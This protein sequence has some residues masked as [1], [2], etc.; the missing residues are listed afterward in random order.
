MPPICRGAKVVECGSVWAVMKGTL[1]YLLWALLAPAALFFAVPMVGDLTGLPMDLPAALEQLDLRTVDWRFRLR[2]PVRP[3]EKIVIVAL[4]QKSVSALGEPPWGRGVNASLLR[5]AKEWGARL[6]VFDMLFATPAARDRKGDDEFAAAVREAGNVVLGFQTTSSPLVEQPMPAVLRRFCVSLATA[7]PVVPRTR[8]VEA[9]F[10]DLLDACRGLGFLNV[11]QDA[12]GAFRNAFALLDYVPAGSQPGASMRLPSLGLAA[13]LALEGIAPA[14]VAFKEGQGLS[15]GGTVMPTGPGSRFAVNF[16]GPAGTFPTYS[17]SDVVHGEVA[18]ETFKGAVVLVGVVLPGAADVRPNPFNLTAYGVELQA[19]ILH[20]ILTRSWI[21][22]PPAY[23]FYVLVVVFSL[24]VGVVVPRIRLWQGLVLV[25][26]VSSIYVTTAVKSFV[27]TRLCLEVVPPLGW[28]GIAYVAAALQMLRAERKTRE[29]VR[30]SFERYLAP[31]VVEE[32]VRKREVALPMGE[33]RNISVLFADIRDFTATAEWLDPWQ[34]TS[35][36]NLFFDRAAAIVFHYGG[37]VDKY[38]GD[39]VMALFGILPG[40]DDHP[41]RAVACALELQ[42]EAETMADEWK[43]G[44][45]TQPLQ[46]AVAINSGEAVVGEVGTRHH[47][48]Y[49]AIGDTVNLASRL[50]ELCPSLSAKILVSQSTHEQVS[51]FVE[52]EFVGEVEIRGRGQKVEVFRI[53]GARKRV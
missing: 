8:R 2:G 38:V 50:E 46:V 18:K 29:M 21:R 23:L 4:D 51:R 22:Y 13:A 44:G 37:V 53:L 25:G 7:S 36:L 17:F 43:F 6:V 16:V 14:R 9:P 3:E 19:N 33:R 40:Q 1:A 49:T 41:R 31:T 12:D 32:I 26:A 52:S 39:C 24:L 15:F 45:A 10:P 30:R 11:P 47:T 48:Q 35:L 5:Q 27:S 28:L 20:T 34:V 42:R